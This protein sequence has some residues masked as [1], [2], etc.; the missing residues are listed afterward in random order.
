MAQK[1]DK[2]GIVKAL[3]AYMEQKGGQNKAANSIKGVSSATLSQM[4]AGAGPGQGDKWEHISEEMWRKVAK[5]IGYGTN[6]WNTAATA[7]YL[8]VHALLRGAQEES[9]VMSLTAP[10]G[11]GKTYAAKE[12]EASHRNV[13]RLMCD[14]FWSKND[15]VE[16]LLRAMGEKAIGLTK[17]ERLALACSVLSKKEKPLLI[18]DEFDKLGDNVWSFFITLYNRLEGQCGMVLLSTDYIEKR[19]RMGL[20]SQRRGYPEIWSRLGSRCV[21]LDRADY[22]DVKMVC[23]ANG[24]TDEAVIEDIARSAEGDLRRVRQ[25]VFANSRRRVAADKKANANR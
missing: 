18:F 13:Y 12:Y 9:R 16:E 11:S 24:L 5:A 3:K 2:K 7:T 22:A 23:E 21:E 15:F 20:K 25:L 14:E 10:A 4:V 1:I 17:R 19:M 6:G 8:Q